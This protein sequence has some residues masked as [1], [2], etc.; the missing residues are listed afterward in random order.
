MAVNLLN[1]KMLRAIGKKKSTPET[2]KF[3]RQMHLTRLEKR[4]GYHSTPR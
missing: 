4:S 1:G 2:N 3:V